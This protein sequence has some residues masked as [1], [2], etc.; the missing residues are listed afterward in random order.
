MNSE[1]NNNENNNE[2][3]N[4]NVT[5][6][7][8]VRDAITSKVKIV[9]LSEDQMKDLDIKDK[10]KIF[11]ENFKMQLSIDK[12]RSPLYKPTNNNLS[13]QSMRSDIHRTNIQN[14]DESPAKYEENFTND[15]NNKVKLYEKVH[16]SKLYTGLN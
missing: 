7:I 4:N 9:N 8:R 6:Y 14:L 11:V 16:Y 1:N 12:S 3:I 15:L 2:K 13:Q 10:N 5:S